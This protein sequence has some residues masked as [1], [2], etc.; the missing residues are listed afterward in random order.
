MCLAGRSYL[1]AAV[2]IAVGSAGTLSLSLR[3]ETGKTVTVA[4]GDGTRETLSLAGSTT[5]TASHTYTQAGGLCLISGSL[6]SLTYLAVSGTAGPVTNINSLVCCTG[7]RTLLLPAAVGN[8]EL[9]SLLQ[10][11]SYFSV[12]AQSAQAGLQLVGSLRSVGSH[13]WACFNAAGSAID[14]DLEDAF[15]GNTTLSLLRLNYTNISGNMGVLLGAPLTAIALDHLAS[16]ICYTVRSTVVLSPN[17]AIDCQQSSM[18][19]GS[20]G[21]LLVA[22]AAASTTW[23]APTLNVCGNGVTYEQLSIAGRTAYDSMVAPNGKWTVTIDKE[24]AK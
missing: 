15:D 16:L 1:A 9:L 21:N 3:G 20:V 11:L 24:E 6:R 18:T 14:G 13:A 8:I 4:Y 17:V 7:L 19:A 23:G 5:V 2:R 22:L 10:S 12:T